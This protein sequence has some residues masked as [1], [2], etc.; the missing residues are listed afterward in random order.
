MRD[1][2]R[3]STL[4]LFGLEEALERVARLCGE[5]GGLNEKGSPAAES[6]CCRF[7]RNVLRDA[8]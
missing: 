6:V 3:V 4:D 5:V 2:R 1:W 8:T 7:E